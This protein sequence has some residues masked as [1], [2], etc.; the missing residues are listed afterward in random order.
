MKKMKE[1]NN[2]NFLKKNADKINIINVNKQN[3]KLSNEKTDRL[4][5]QSNQ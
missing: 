4:K 2:F 3:K 1:G 5:N